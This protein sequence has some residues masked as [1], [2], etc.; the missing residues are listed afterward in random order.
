MRCLLG[1]ALALAVCGGTSAAADPVTVTSGTIVFTDE[2]GFFD[3]SGDGFDISLLW[4]PRLVSGTPFGKHCESGCVPG[5][6]VDFG[7]TTH[8]FAA[9]QAGG[10]VDG[11]M[12]PM[13]FAVGELTF[14]GPQFSA[15]SF[16]ENGLARG[17]FTFD[18]NLSIFTDEPHT[19]PPVFARELTGQGTATV[20]GDVV[21]PGGLFSFQSGD[22][23]HYTFTSPVPEPATLVMLVSGLVGG[24]AGLRRRRHARNAAR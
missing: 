19:A 10:T 8:A 20:F 6:A 7:T 12:Y 21:S 22:D 4:S 1:L 3:I 9:F 23:L 2:P 17:A 14:N 18:G 16:D 5:T 13:L 11:V 15:P 24:A